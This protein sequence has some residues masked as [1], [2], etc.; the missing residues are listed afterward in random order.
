MLDV[1]TPSH[2]A[3]AIWRRA[4]C[5]HLNR[6]DAQDLALRFLSRMKPASI[7]AY[8]RR[9]RPVRLVLFR[10]DGLLRGCAELHATG[11]G[12]A[13][14]AVS[15]ERG[16]Q[17]RGLGRE[18]AR[19]ACRE[20]L[21]CGFRSIEILCAQDN[22][23]MRRIARQLSADPVPAGGWGLARFRLSGPGNEIRP[24]GEMPASM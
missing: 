5:A 1:L 9:A 11:D 21:S 13:E 3:D 20:A 6:L 12:C 19:R 18:M 15:L 24:D 16:W 4:L 14:I 10:P 22:R 17:G 23:A 2:D 7:D 8:C